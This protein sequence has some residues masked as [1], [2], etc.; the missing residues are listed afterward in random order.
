MNCHRV[1]S[2]LSAYLDQELSPEE[3]RLIR[4]HIF[5]CPSCAE[6]FEELSKIKSY[7][8]NLEP[9]S[10]R[11]DLCD[12]SFFG[13]LQADSLFSVNPWIWGKRLGLTTTCVF[14]FL[15]TAFYLFPVDQNAPLMVAEETAPLSLSPAAPPY[16]L[17]SEEK[18]N[19]NL[20]L[21]VDKEQEEKKRENEY[22]FLPDSSH[23]LPGVPV[24]R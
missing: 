5:Y 20:F 1:Q 11:V 16:Q 12:H 14:L 17:V 8:G 2:L 10:L 9:P 3:L 18:T 6:N 15:L 7:L 19:A 23:L 22:Y 24:S 21:E 4:N 13:H